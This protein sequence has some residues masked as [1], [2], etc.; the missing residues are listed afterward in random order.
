MTLE[1]MKL[2]QG[3]ISYY[4]CIQIMFS[5]LVFLLGR[6][7]LDVYETGVYEN[8]K[9]VF[10]RTLTFVT[11]AF[12]GIGPYLNKK[13]LKYSFLKR[14]FFMLISIVVQIIASIIVY[15]VLKNLL[16]AIFL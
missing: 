7:V 10:Q 4:L 15:Y 5:T 9:T 1:T 6:I 11:N 2:I 14:K 16:R 8:P 12:L 13:F 3:L